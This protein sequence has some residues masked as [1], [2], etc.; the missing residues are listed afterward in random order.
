MPKKTTF[1]PIQLKTNLIF[2]LD[3]Y[4]KTKTMSGRFFWVLVF[5]VFAFPSKASDLVFKSRV[6]TVLNT[7][8]LYPDSS[9][10]SNANTRFSEGELLEVIG[11]SVLEHLDDSQ[12]QKFKWF[13]VRNQAGLE[14]WIFGDGIAVIMDTDKINTQL[15]SFHKKKISLNNG[16]EKSVMWIAG[17]E[18][19]DNLHDNDFLNPTY[20]EYYLVITNEYGQSVHVNYESQSAMGRTETQLIQF[21]DLTGD[22]VDEILLQTKSYSASSD[23]E[24][25]VFEISS[26]QSGSLKKVLEERMTLTYDDDLFS[27]AMFKY[28]EVSGQSIRVEFVDFI[29]CRK[30]S[31]PYQFENRSQTQER[32]LEFV[33]YTYAWDSR[34]K[35]FEQFYK[36]N[37]NALKAIVTRPKVFIFSEPSFLSKKVEKLTPH[38]PLIV[39]QHFEK[40][41]LTNG[42][43]KI[44]TYLLVQ[45]KKGNR[46]YLRGKDVQFLNSEHASTLSNYY[47]NTPL[48]KTDLKPNRTFLK[49]LNDIEEGGSAQKIKEKN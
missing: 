31:L 4:F 3:F 16:F 5:F 2:L 49:I 12:N 28:I 44:S 8:T 24:N 40:M 42:K 26:I 39:I 13:K 7:V 48:S 18:G 15:S 1:L 37:R 41:Y 33:T 35:R 17:I 19:R 38:Q 9:Y 30:Y 32:C 34:K 25:R 23:L 11:E 47:K 14:G 29:A 46:G 20:H 43:K 21:K 22:Q 36:E 10:F 45:S 6:A 27:P